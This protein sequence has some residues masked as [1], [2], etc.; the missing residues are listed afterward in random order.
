MDDLAMRGSGGRDDLRDADGADQAA[1]GGAADAGR[2]EERVRE[3]A[4][5]APGVAPIVEAAVLDTGTDPAIDPLA[6]VADQRAAMARAIELRDDPSLPPEERQRWADA[7]ERL[8]AARHDAKDALAE[9]RRHDP[10]LE[11]WT[12]AEARAREQARQDDADPDDR[13]ARDATGTG[14]DS[15]RDEPAAWQ[16]PAARVGPET[17]LDTT[18]SGPRTTDQ[19]TSGPGLAGGTGGAGTQNLPADT[20]ADPSTPL[21]PRKD[22]EPP[23]VG[24]R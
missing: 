6:V 3:V 23:D 24:N 22:A 1:E 14:M 12:E 13:S 4:E 17:G 19:L 10:T 11:T 18:P 8:A 16:P 15:G 7:V 2:L 9:R 21:V 5:A 20:G